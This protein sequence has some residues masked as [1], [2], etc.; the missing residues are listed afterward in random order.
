[1]IKTVY[2]IITHYAINY[3]MLQLTSFANWTIS[4]ISLSTLIVI[5]QNMDTR[6]NI[7]YLVYSFIIPC[8]MHF[9]SILYDGSNNIVI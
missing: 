3:V 8:R 1:M 2:C 4:S 9:L 7:A 5:I 6:Y